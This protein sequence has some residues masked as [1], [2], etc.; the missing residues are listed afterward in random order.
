M[1]PFFYL[2][3]VIIGV[4]CLKE[5]EETELANGS[6][7]VLS[8]E[9]VAVPDNA[10]TSYLL[11]VTDWSLAEDGRALYQHIFEDDY[12]GLQAISSTSD[13][14]ADLRFLLSK[15][16]PNLTSFLSVDGIFSDAQLLTLDLPFSM[17]DGGGFLLTQNA[18]LDLDDYEFFFHAADSGT[19]TPI[20]VTLSANGQTAVVDVEGMGTVIVR[21][22]PCSDGNP[23]D[24]SGNCNDDPIEIT[25]PDLPFRI[26][27]DQ[28]PDFRRFTWPAGL[29][30]VQCSTDEGAIWG[31]CTTDTSFVMLYN[32]FNAKIILQVRGTD[33]E[34]NLRQGSYDLD[35]PQFDHVTFYS[36]DHIV[37][38]G[39]HFGEVEGE[40]DDN[41][42]ICFAPGIL[43]TDNFAGAITVGDRGV[44]F[45][46]DPSDPATL[47][48][49]KTGGSVPQ[50]S[51]IYIDTQTGGAGG[52][53]DA[54]IAN[55]KIDIYGNN[56]IAIKFADFT[57]QAP[58]FPSTNI[59]NDLVS[60]VE[61]I[62]TGD[63]ASGIYSTGGRK[64]VV[65]DCK[66]D[67]PVGSQ[68]KGIAIS[69]VE[70]PGYVE[71][72]YARANVNQVIYFN[73]S[74]A[75]VDYDGVVSHIRD[76]T[77]VRVDCA[78]APLQF[79]QT[80]SYDMLIELDGNTIETG[81]HAIVA[82]SNVD[83]DLNDNIFVAGTPAMCTYDAV[84]TGLQMNIDGAGNQYCKKF[85]N[86]FT[87]ISSV[88][89]LTGNFSTA[90]STG[91]VCPANTN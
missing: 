69:F 54:I 37:Q 7:T 87:A 11:S 39:D 47:R 27:N 53:S 91:G 38:G 88:S 20:N 76:S 84:I 23:P 61:V 75:G 15:D 83:L 3:L 22:K 41:K 24:A 71:S 57:T 31:D 49:T 70:S 16:I 35:D 46:G 73:T 29:S 50:E 2:I 78:G 17:F 65:A 12:L 80:D 44:K 26:Y 6:T 21:R 48:N 82:G 25:A 77:V 55:L 8:Y 4:S 33:S 1:K 74:A 10:I 90:S 36:C 60:N 72:T 66:V 79:D 58:A 52:P 28:N 40:Q 68:G 18:S 81:Y 89:T 30:N 67:Y 9:T 14:I 51:G 63:Y 64:T 19:E 42:V 59:S 56:G 43:V 34:G 32:D 62:R 86:D 85:A 5:N 45:I 13:P